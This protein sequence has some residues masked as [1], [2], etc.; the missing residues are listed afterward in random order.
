MIILVCGGRKYN[1]L[2]RLEAV[3]DDTFKLYPSALILQGGAPGADFLA[4][5]HAAARG[6]PVATVP[7]NW[8]VYDRRAGTLR[9]EW[10]LFYFQ[11]ELVIAFPGGNGTANMVKLAKQK[12]IRVWKVR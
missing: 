1:D 6:F 10:M 9:N 11:V 3:L 5:K 8:D 7:A 4:A 2:K 12:D